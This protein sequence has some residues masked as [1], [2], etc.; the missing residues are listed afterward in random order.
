MIKNFAVAVILTSL[1]GASFADATPKGTL[2]YSN[3]ITFEKDSTSIS[4]RGIN[5]AFRSV[6]EIYERGYRVVTSGFVPDPRSGGSSQTMYFVIE[7]R[8]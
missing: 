1:C 7:E 6:A 5:G 8:K 3:N 2:C 4:C